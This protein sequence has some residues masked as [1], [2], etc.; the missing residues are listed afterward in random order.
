MDDPFTLGSV[1]SAT[2]SPPRSTLPLLS[3]TS[4]NIIYAAKG[5]KKSSSIFP[6]GQ[7]VC[8]MMISISFLLLATFSSID[9]PSSSLNFLGC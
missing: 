2:E 3:L 4:M 6:E 7:L 5:K 8:G 1:I 9:L